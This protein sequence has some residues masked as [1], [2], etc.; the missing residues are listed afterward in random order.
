MVV[1][2]LSAVL[3]ASSWRLLPEFQLSRE[4]LRLDVLII[5]R[6]GKPRPPALLRPEV[7]LFG[8]HTLLHVKGATDEPE[9]GDAL[10]LVAYGCLYVK[11]ERL[12]GTDGVVLVLLANR[13]TPRFRRQIEDLGGQLGERVPGLWQ[14]QVAGFTLHAI[15]TQ[16]REHEPGERL[17]YMLSKDVLEKPGDLGPLTEPELDICR[18]LYRHVEQLGH[19]EDATMIKDRQK[20]SKSYL[21]ALQRLAEV[22]PIEARLAGLA[23]EQRLA[24]LA[25]EQL[26]PSLPEELLRALSAEY[27]A[28]LPASVRRAVERRRALLPPHKAKSAASATASR[29]PPPSKRRRS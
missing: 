10:S 19:R 27:L 8:R 9:P 3:P 5:R 7:A 29:P 21:E 16:V 11:Q 2:L 4:P 18:V 25:A 15:E 12:P 14:G 6:V 26:L 13:L 17:L 23:P 20:L 24:G 22:M 1:A 28:T